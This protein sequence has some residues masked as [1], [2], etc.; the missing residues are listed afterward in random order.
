MEPIRC[1]LVLSGAVS[2]GAYEAGAV[3]QLA[4]ALEEWNREKPRFVVDAIAGASAGA[5]VGSMFAFHLTTGQTASEFLEK[6]KRVWTGKTSSLLSLIQTTPEERYALLSSW[7]LLQAAEEFFGESPRPP[8]DSGPSEVILTLTLT[9]LDGSLYNVHLWDWEGKPSERPSLRARTHRDWVT[10]RCRPGG[11]VEELG[12]QGPRPVSWRWV[13]LAALASGAFPFA[14]QPFRLTRHVGDYQRLVGEVSENTCVQYLYADGGILD[15][16]PL[17]QAIEAVKH[18]QVPARFARRLYLMLEPHP[19]REEEPRYIT[20]DIRV[21]D[22]PFPEPWSLLAPRLLAALREQSVYLDLYTSQ[23]V[24][25]RL[26]WRKEQWLPLLT[27]LVASLP[28]EKVEGLL[29]QVQEAMRDI[30]DFKSRHA[31][32]SL[33]Q[34]FWG[35]ARRYL[36]EVPQGQAKALSPSRRRLLLLLLAMSDYI[37]G[38]RDKHEVYVARIHPEDPERE[39]AGEFLGHFGGFLDPRFR[40]HDF[41]RGARDMHRWLLA[42]AK[43]QWGEELSLT[44]LWEE[45]TLSPSAFH[46]AQA[47]WEAFPLPIRRRYLGA[48]MAKV[49]HLLAEELR[50]VGLPLPSPFLGL[51]PLL[52]QGWLH[53]HLL[54]LACLALLALAALG[55]WQLAEVIGRLLVG[56]G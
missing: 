11:Q 12:V 49:Q 43:E 46:L 28:Q 23:K 1:A 35:E 39:L 29:Q 36:Q 33:P 19:P 17:K 30:A 40:A 5:M 56:R 8:A 13:A 6:L 25:Q 34:F 44:P 48:L 24:N 7:P 50:R 10:F 45:E 22:G 15:N 55:L 4:Q 27:E 51:F 18:L 37:G 16:T 9:N 26:A 53:P 41:S 3:A 42:W 21:T 38:L 52:M 32:R 14:F 2:L 20:A 47:R 54:T 31:G